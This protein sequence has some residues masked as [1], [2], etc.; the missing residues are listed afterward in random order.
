M[1]DATD[2]E[3]TAPLHP[4]P[5]AKRRRVRK[6]T[7]SCWECKRR[8]IR[9]IFSSPDDVSCIGCQQRRAP[10]VSQHMPEDLSPAKKGS[11]HL[12]E[13]IAK[14][15]DFI[16]N[17]VA[18]NAGDSASQTEE[19]AQKER[20]RLDSS[21]RGL[22]KDSAL[23]PHSGGISGRAN[24]E[25]S[26][27]H[28]LLA[29]FLTE[30]DAKVLLSA[31]SK[32]SLYT[33]LVNTQPHSKLTLES[34]A[35]SYPAPELAGPNTHPVLLARQMLMFAITLQSPCGERVCGL[36]EP[37]GVLMR[38]LMTAATTSVITKEEMYGTVE[39]LVCIMLEGVFEVNSG[40]LRRGWAVYRRAMTVAQLMGL[41]RSPIPPLKHID[42]ESK[43]DP[44]FMWFRIVYMDRYL[45]LLLGLP[46]GTTDRSMGATSALQHE[47]P[48]GK[49]ERQLTVIA[50]DILERNESSFVA[51]A[52]TTTR[53]IDSELLRLSQ[54]M[55]AS[56]WR[57]VNFHNLTIGSPETLLE[58][59]RLA[60]QVYYYGLLIQLHLPY[61]MNR[62]GDHAEHEY[63]KVTSVNASREIIT[64]FIA[65][66]TFNPMSS[67]SRPVDFFAFLAGMTL[68]L[69]HLD[70]HRHPESPN[71]LAHQRSSD[72]AM[73]DQALER[74]DAISK[75]NKDATTRK[76]AELITRL[77]DIEA[78][79]AKGSIYTT[80][81]VPE[82]DQDAAEGVEDKRDE[83]RL[84]IPYLGVV[85]IAR[86]NPISCERFNAGLGSDPISSSS[87]AFPPGV[88][89]PGASNEALAPL[90]HATLAE[91]L[92]P[93]SQR[94]NAP[95]QMWEYNA[96]SSRQ[97]PTPTQGDSGLEPHMRLPGITASVD[98]WA[99]QGVDMAF[100]D[101]LMKGMPGVDDEDESSI[102]HG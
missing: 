92:H 8:K 84:H 27:L 20:R 6:G 12:G 32:S 29:T 83:L 38:R 71:F 81:T 76:S 77:L 97:W 91:E 14:V 37:Q 65:H 43:A 46:Q 87:I 88:L 94:Q 1:N 18:G 100:F 99:F 11:R 79:A 101:S 67:C 19:G 34:L 61:M 44:K 90:S 69:A 13:R 60:S 2:E 66:R 82:A 52:T 17:Y 95:L 10:C 58:T 93:P 48:L 39:G 47:P 80:N 49:F 31:S 33:E 50:S 74:M 72:R 26:A 102:V 98:D 16:K 23:A 21:A 56:F 7:R 53:S 25:R 9:C 5:S 62:V 85:K 40:N 54:S 36:S 57:P 68:L 64:R 45:S 59:V 42:P 30:R 35:A 4:E 89:V 22:A 15:E 86:E 78:D 51:S 41:H 75:M 24:P 70:A 73:L 63:S 96:Q 3:S 55:P 28:H